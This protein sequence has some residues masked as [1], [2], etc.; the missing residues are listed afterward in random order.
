MDAPAMTIRIYGDDCLRTKSKPIN[1]VG[2]EERLLIQ[3]MLTTMYASQ[4]IGLA[5]PQ[6]GINQRLFVVDIG[7]GPVAV[8]NPK[9]LKTKGS[10]V[11][12]E[13]CLSLPG[14]AVDVK[15]PQRI[16]VQYL[17]QDNRSVQMEL[18]DLMARVFLHESDH[19]QGKL[20]SDYAPFYKK[21]RLS[22][23][24]KSIASADRK[25]L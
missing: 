24:L 8:I 16:V 6:I 25:I 12:E 3:G 22:K 20:I 13:G 14:V 19:L 11:M 9:I 5:A 1:A 18:S 7:Q 2:P 10:D 4:G 17:D 23:S 15:R 21:F